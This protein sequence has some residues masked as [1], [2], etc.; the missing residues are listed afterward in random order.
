[1]K[2]HVFKTRFISKR[3]CIEYAITY[4]NVTMFTLLV[5]YLP[6]MWLLASRKLWF[7]EKLVGIDRIHHFRGWRN[8]EDLA[9][10]ENVNFEVNQ[11][12]E[13]LV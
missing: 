1:M 10:T 4:T 12:W 6:A 2:N 9:T 13:L 8:R 5:T 11:I 7:I 3:S